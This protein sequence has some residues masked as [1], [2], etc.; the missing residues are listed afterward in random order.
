M[1][2]STDDENIANL[3]VTLGLLEDSPAP[4]EPQAVYKKIIGGLG[5]Y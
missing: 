5:I 1:L 3:Y 2:R 4:E